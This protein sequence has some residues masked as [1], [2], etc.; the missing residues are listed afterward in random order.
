MA[1]LSTNKDLVGTNGATINYTLSNSYSGDSVSY[2]WDF[3][4]TSRSGEIYT[5]LS[6]NQYG[7]STFSATC[8][9]TIGTKHTSTTGE[10]EN[11]TTTTTWT[12]EDFSEN[13]SITVFLH[14]GAFPIGAIQY[15]P[16]N[17]QT[18]SN[19]IISNVL[20]K[21]KI[22]KWI[23]HYNKVYHWWNQSNSNY[24]I[25]LSVVSNSPITAIWFNK[26]MDAMNVFG[27]NYSYVSGGQNGTLIT[28]EIINRLNFN[29][30]G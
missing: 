22:D 10:G 8:T 1:V 29:G 25:D 4:S 19:T 24:P 27:R 9:I 17:N 6:A 3:G 2:S 28:A 20:T 21:E 26:C 23:E 12:Y 14:P 16:N 30:L 13:D 11:Q 18:G 5:K 15:N 7:Y